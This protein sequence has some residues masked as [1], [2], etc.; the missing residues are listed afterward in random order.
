M[1]Y[2]TRGRDEVLDFTPKN[3]HHST[4]DLTG[5]GITFNLKASLTDSENVFQKQNTV[6]GGDDTEVKVIRRS[7]NV[8]LG[9]SDTLALASDKYFY[10]YIVDGEKHESG[11]IRF[12]PMGRL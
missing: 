7:F 5:L 1:L 4:I 10:E 6:D 9:A 3:K 11:Y 12:K 8:F 2:L